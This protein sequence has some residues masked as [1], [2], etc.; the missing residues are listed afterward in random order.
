[1]RKIIMGVV[2]LLALHRLLEGGGGPGGASGAVAAA[3][4]DQRITLG[5]RYGG[6]CG[7]GRPAG[8]HAAECRPDGGGGLGRDRGPLPLPFESALLDRQREVLGH[9]VAMDH[10]AHLQADLVPNRFNAEALAKALAEGANGRR[11]LLVRADRGRQVL[12]EGLGRAGAR[13]DEIVAYS[14]VDTEQP[15]EDVAHALSAGEIDW[16]VATSP[17]TARSLVRLT[18]TSRPPPGARGARSRELPQERGLVVPGLHRSGIHHAGPLG[19]D[20]AEGPTPRLDRLA[21][22]H[23]PRGGDVGG[24][25]PLARQEEGLGVACRSGLFGPAFRGGLGE[26]DRR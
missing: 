11:F 1:M 13:V 12:A 14:S 17:A 18:S 24:P 16:V 7:G 23:L 9:L 22:A 3:G 2:V 20:E 21:L 25:H 6:R 5:C 4:T 10:L 19:M 8:R 15:S 26:I